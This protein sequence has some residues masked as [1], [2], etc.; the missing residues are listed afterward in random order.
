MDIV[1]IQYRKPATL[2]SWLVVP[3]FE[4]PEGRAQCSDGD[5][6]CGI[7]WRC[8]QLQFHHFLVHV[9]EDSHLTALNNFLLSKIGI[10]PHKI[11]VREG[12]I[13]KNL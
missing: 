3:E 8:I 5:H 9:P 13:Q 11:I 2:A 7:G 1:P 4:K 10:I 12:Q 6:G